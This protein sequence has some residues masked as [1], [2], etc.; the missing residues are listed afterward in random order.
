[1]PFINKYNWEK[2]NYLSKNNPTI[3]L[4]IMYTKKKNMSSLYFKL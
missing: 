3:A 4:N 1:M 2:I